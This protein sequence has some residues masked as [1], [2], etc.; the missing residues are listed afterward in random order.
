MFNVYWLLRISSNSL[1]ISVSEGCRNGT[2]E[3]QKER[4]KKQILKK[5]K[6]AEAGNSSENSLR[7]TTAARNNLEK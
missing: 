2:R 7:I 3:E 5:G 6:F 4:E 1:V